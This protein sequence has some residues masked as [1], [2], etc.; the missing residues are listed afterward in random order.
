M[1]NDDTPAPVSQFQ[2]LSQVVD[3]N[4]DNGPMQLDSLCMNCHEQGVTKLLLLRVPYFRDIILESFACDHCHFKDNSVKS[5]GQIQEQGC[6][7]TLNVENE[8]DLQRQVIRSDLSIF[9]VESLGIEMPKG[10]SQLTNV[11]GVIQ[12]IHESLSGEQDLRK[13]QAP[14]LYAALEPI[15]AKLK[16]IMDRNGFPFTISLDDL[17][18]NSWIAPNTTDRGNK[19][20]RHEYPRTHEQNEDLGISH[21]ANANAAEAEVKGP[22]D[23]GNP[24]D[25]DIVDGEVYDLPTECP[26][27]NCQGAST[28]I[29]RVNIPHFKEVY[30]F[31]TSCPECGYKSSDVRTGGEVPAKGKRITLKVENMVDL[32]RDILKSNTCALSSEDLEIEVQPGTLGGR[33][34]SVEGLLTEIKEQLYGHIFDAEGASGGDSMQTSEKSKWERFF[35]NLDAAIA[36]DKKFSITLEDP[37]ANSYVQDLCSPA[38][39]PQITI[40]EYERSAEEEDDLGLT[41][42][43]T[44]GYEKDNKD[45]DEDKPEDKEKATSA[46]DNLLEASMAK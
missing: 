27:C 37:M 23:M 44:E 45:E 43:K 10:E 4:D 33:F 28:R 8:D 26:G 32:S 21:D 46:M 16:D 2:D 40:E 13:D 6:K 20:I 5:A 39:D 17:T 3:G 22:N 9:K 42:M 41:D 38:V 7:Y 34:T 24:E 25:L 29:K 15:I 18:G 14:E 11:E 19:Y 31:G 35:D 1:L 30:I 36:G 12:R